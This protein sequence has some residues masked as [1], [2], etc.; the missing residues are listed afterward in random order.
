VTLPGTVADSGADLPPRRLLRGARNLQGLIGRS[1]LVGITFVGEDGG[2]LRREQ[3]F[4]VI[5]ESVDGV[6]TVHRA[7]GG[8]P[9]VLPADEESFQPAKPGTYRL[10]GTGQEVVDPDYL[11]T[12]TV[13]VHA[14]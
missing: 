3:A 9:V 7:D 11:T 13:V 14:G 2:L 1:V 10:S 4:G 12:W 8:E 5:A 6:V